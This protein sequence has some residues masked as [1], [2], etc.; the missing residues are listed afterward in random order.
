MCRKIQKK[1]LTAV[2]NEDDKLFD[3]ALKLL[4]ILLRMR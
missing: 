1:K 4:Q 3:A 2:F